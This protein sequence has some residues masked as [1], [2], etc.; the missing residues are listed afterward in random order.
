MSFSC[1]VL[2][3]R[4]ASEVL[5]IQQNNNTEDLLCIFCLLLCTYVA[6]LCFPDMFKVPDAPE[7]HQEFHHSEVSQN[8]CSS[9]PFHVQACDCLL[10]CLRCCDVGEVMMNAIQ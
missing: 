5:K 6:N 7:M 4:F 8:S 1:L 9:Y 3:S 2:Q 10:L